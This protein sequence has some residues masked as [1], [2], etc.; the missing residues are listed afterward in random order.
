VKQQMDLIAE[1]ATKIRGTLLVDGDKSISH[2]AAL[3]GALATGESRISGF[4]PGEDTVHTAKM[5]QAMGAQV[6]TLS[7]TELRITGVGLRQLQ[8]PTAPLDCGNAGTGMRLMAGILVGQGFASTLIGDAS[9]SRRP[10]RRV[11]APL[12]LMGADIAG[13]E[14]DTAPLRIRPALQLQGIDYQSPVASAQVKSCVL[15]AGLYAAG[16]TSVS[17]PEVT[18]DHTERMLRN[19]G[20]PVEVT[21]KTARLQQAS[22][23]FACDVAVPADPSSAAFFAVAAAI[24]EGSDVVLPNVC[25]N[26]RRT[27]IFDTLIDMGADIQ[28]DNQRI[29]GGEPVS[30]VR[31]R[32]RGLVGVKVPKARVGDMIDEF[33]IFFIAASCAKGISEVVG[34]EELR[35]KESDRIGAMVRGLHTL[36]I[37]AEERP[38][39]VMIEGGQLQ[40]GVI[41]SKGDHRIAMSFA[42]ASLR[43]RAAIKILDCANIATSFPGFFDLATRAGL[44]LQRA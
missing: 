17:E 19:F 29:L 23:L 14:A 37:A 11:I 35:V 42:I 24:V 6:R 22:A 41:D 1:P 39:G 18:R 5:M 16:S 33:P 44:Q 13:T 9:L 40:G 8:A 12:R 10:M 43:A 21:G 26:P 3:F 32:G 7:R 2:R 28:F 15:L 34:A 31:V 25:I 4:L 20:V 27:G 30:D 36:G 38:D